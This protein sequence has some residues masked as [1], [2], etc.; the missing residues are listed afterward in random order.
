MKIGTIFIIS[1]VL[2]VTSCKKQTEK[3]PEA[4]NA[5]SDRLEIITHARAAQ[6]EQNEATERRNNLFEEISKKHQGQ[7]P[8]K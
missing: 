7:L 3:E 8:T 4:G 1:L 6:R 2:L 5:I